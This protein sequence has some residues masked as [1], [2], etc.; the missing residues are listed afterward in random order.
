MEA[1]RFDRVTA[2][3]L[4]ENVSFV[5]PG[6]ALASLVT[7]K[8]EA[9]ELLVRLMLGMTT[10]DAGRVTVLG[11]DLTGVSEDEVFGLRR[12]ISVVHPSGGLVSNLKVWENL[13]L[14]LEYQGSK[15]PAEIEKAGLAVL[16]RLGYEGRLME[17]PGPLPLYKK[18]LLGLGRAMLSEPELIIYSGILTGISGEERGLIV[19]TALE[20]HREREGRTSI[21]ITADPQSIG[22]ISFDAKVSL[23]QGGVA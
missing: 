8:N 9:S 14:P 10:A 6:G 11:C 1:V 20:F 3:S 18:R 2:D 7:P 16:R 4:L 13:V 23:I 5:I 17:L 12:R 19:K 15:A 22:G 21:F